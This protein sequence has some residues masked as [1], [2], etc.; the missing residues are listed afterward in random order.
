MVQPV[1]DRMVPAA[2]VYKCPAAEVNKDP[3]EH[4]NLELVYR[5]STA[6]DSADNFVVRAAHNWSTHL[7]GTSAGHCNWD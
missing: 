3:A 1:A 5:R 2:G 6:G 7:L 4:R